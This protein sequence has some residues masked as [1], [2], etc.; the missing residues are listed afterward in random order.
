MSHMKRKAEMAKQPRNHPSL[1]T[2]DPYYPE[3]CEGYE[4]IDRRCI[5]VLEVTEQETLIRLLDKMRTSYT[6]RAMTQYIEQLE[7]KVSA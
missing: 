6:T 1:P 7:A 4:V 3:G 5:D 2:K